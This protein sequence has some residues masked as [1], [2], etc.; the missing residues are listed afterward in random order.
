MPNLD[1]I[2]PLRTSQDNFISRSPKKKRRVW[3]W[4]AV[5]AVIIGLGIWGGSQL[6]SK[7]NKIF[8]NKGN[9]F[10]RISNLLISPDKKLIGE[11]TGTVNILLM[12][13]GGEGHEGAHLT[14]TMIVASIDLNTHEVV[15]LSIP[16]DFS[17]E[18]PKYG[19]NRINAAYAYAYKDDPD[20]AGDAAIAAVEKVTGL[21]IPY[22]AVIDFAGF[23]KAI[24]DV[25]GVDITID[26]TFTDAEYPNESDG[27]LSPV[28]FT[29]GTEHMDGTRALIFARS[30]HGNNNEGSDFARSE[31]QKKIIA[32]F[33]DKV[34]KLNLG[35][36]KTITNLLGDFTDNFRTNL[37]PYE[38]KR[39]S[40]LGKGIN[41]DNIYSF[42]L[43]P[44]GN[45]ICSELIDANT[46]QRIV[47][48]PPT[49]TP[50][51]TTTTTPPATDTT[52][53]STSSSTS[54]STKTP[55]TS[56]PTSSTSSD[57]TDTEPTTPTVVPMYVIEPCAGKTFADIQKFVQLAPMLAKLKK[58]AAVIDIQNSTGQA[59]AIKKY[60]IL[61][62]Y[63]MV[64]KYPIFS[65]RT[66]YQNTILYD[67]SAGRK[68]HTLDYL[69]ANYQFIT[70]DVGFP[71]SNADF[72]IVVGKDTP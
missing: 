10:S 58:E 20:T 23:I 44:Q 26:R 27:Y 55:S 54:T 32:A 47:A 29:K 15:L 63:G 67:N 11:D 8:T 36:L 21:D 33:K 43:E 53:K 46:G 52:K 13:I 30:R 14:D 49:A 69:K 3:K 57:T 17:F 28:T 64:L 7:T 59:S 6:I 68:P 5:L 19:F 18:L 22:Y 37:E 24:N 65:G 45:L 4:L 12:G 56:Q 48:P 34:L 38:L 42:S 16:R 35:D 70:S 60:S 41:S 25:G 31:R 2:K 71:S 9:I 62:D 50:D 51:P 40:D 66:T 1:A 61:A 39:L 72:V